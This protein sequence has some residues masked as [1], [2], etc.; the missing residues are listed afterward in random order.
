MLA[1]YKHA[2]GYPLLKDEKLHPFQL[3]IGQYQTLRFIKEL[4]IFLDKIKCHAVIPVSIIMDT[5][6]KLLY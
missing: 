6:P 2:F 5:L 3:I 4:Q 1:K